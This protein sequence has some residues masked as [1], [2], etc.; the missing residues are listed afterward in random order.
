MS[1]KPIKTSFLLGERSEV[2]KF[3]RKS[4]IKGVLTVAAL[5]SL[6]ELWPDFDANLISTGF[7]IDMIQDL[8]NQD[9]RSLYVS[10]ISHLERGDVKLLQDH[11]HIIRDNDTI[12]IESYGKLTLSSIASDI[13][14]IVG[15][16]HQL[17]VTVRPTTKLHNQV[18]YQV[19]NFILLP[20]GSKDSALLMSL[21]SSLVE[22][23]Q[24]PFSI[25]RLSHVSNSLLVPTTKRFQTQ[26][27]E[28]ICGF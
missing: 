22:A 8:I 7:I 1:F 16:R 17:N 2:R 24:F 12:D 14:K 19:Q 5:Q 20:D 25:L 4:I 23:S 11:L 6:P 15:W 3:M 26:N 10:L 9:L 13:H 27:V 18:V 21:L 28:L